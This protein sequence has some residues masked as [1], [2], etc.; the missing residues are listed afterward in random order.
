[1]PRKLKDIDVAEISL[2]DNAANRKKFYIVKRRRQMDEFIKLLKSF[3]G[4]DDDE[5]KLSEEDIAKAEKLDEKAIKAIQGALNIL[6]KYKDVYPNDVLTAIKT[7]TKYA[8]Y[9]YSYPAKKSLTEEELIEELT[10][11]EKAG[12]KLSKATIEQLKKAMEIIQSLIEEK[13]EDITKGH[14]LPPEIVKKLEKL[15][16]YEKAE[17]ERIEKERIEKEKK[18]EELIKELKERVEKLEK[19]KGIKK[20]IDGQD[21]DD[22]DKDKNKGVKWPSLISSQED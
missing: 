8:A 9:G 3:M 13:E 17:K 1:M 5:F 11:V 18:Q 6:N 7:L 2:V 15:A 19:S 4:E 12:R 20:S 10:D 22:D 14:K 16:E 21:D